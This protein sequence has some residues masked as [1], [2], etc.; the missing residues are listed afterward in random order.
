M[1]PVFCAGRD[2]QEVASWVAHRIPGCERGWTR[3]AA[4]AVVNA[5]RIAG[6]VVFHNWAPESGVIE[7]SAAADDPRW[8]TREALHKMHAY[9][10]DEAGCRLTVMRVS[11]RNKRICRI[12]RA[13]GYEGTRIP[14]MR[15]PDEAEMI[16]TLGAEDWRAGR[17]YRSA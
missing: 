1:T 10:F 14:R 5:G 11:E 8:L 12:A 17:F 4:M 7:M 13:F 16:F 3:C 6:A 15:G 9:A 2:A